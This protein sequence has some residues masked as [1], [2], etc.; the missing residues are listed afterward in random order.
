MREHTYKIDVDGIVWFDGEW[1]EDPVVYRAFYENM[2]H[3][4]DGRL[5]ADCLG[6]RCWIDAEDTP[7]VVQA[8]DVAAD[9]SQVALML[10][11]GI[12]ERLDPAT[13]QVGRDNVLYA[14]VKDGAFP[15]RF[16]RKAYYEL[17]RYIAPKDGAFV[18]QL[19]GRTWPIPG[20]PAP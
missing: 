13:L 14:R 3:A 1:Y 15:A 6:E 20:A 4:S 16:T 12:E 17:A 5:Y 19:G 7:F 9:G 8:L 11:G 2:T 18:L 10:T